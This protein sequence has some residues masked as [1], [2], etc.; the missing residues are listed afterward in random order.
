[1]ARLSRVHQKLFAGQ[2]T[3]NGVFGSLQA[4]DPQTSN[5]VATLQSLPAFEEGWDSA[6]YS[7]DDLPPLEEFQGIQYGI[8]Y[9]QCYML[10]EGIPEW[11]TN[12][13]YYI[14]SLAKEV[15]AGGF[16][17]YSSNTD[18]NT[19]NALSNT[20]YWKL[21]MDS[22]DL[23]FRTSQIQDVAALPVNPDADTYYFV[24]GA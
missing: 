13:T 14:G 19:G 2:A 10:Q 23:Y 18:N 9:Q 22:S 1:M 12:A 21:V 4:N 15:T 7:A 17:L 8:S 5:D 6:T 11:N 20:T 3:N 24:T 16:K